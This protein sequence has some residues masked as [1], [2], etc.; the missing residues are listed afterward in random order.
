MQTV[1]ELDNTEIIPGTDSTLMQMVQEEWKIAA[2]SAAQY[3]SNMVGWGCHKQTVNR[4]L[5]PFSHIN[6]VVTA[7]EWDNFFGLRLHKDAQPE[8]RELAI[9]MWLA[10]QAKQT[11]QTPR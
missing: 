5:E 7:T 10:R 4:L 2:L 11:K 1:E 8:M 9:K 6:V 3:A